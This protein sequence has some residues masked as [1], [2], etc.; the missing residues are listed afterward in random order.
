[1][2]P[3]GVQGTKTRSLRGQVADVHGVEAVHVFRG[4]DRQ[5]NLLGVDVRGQGQ[6][7]QDAVDFVA[8]VQFGDQG[9]QVFGG[10]AFRGSVLL[11]VEADF[12]GALDL[13]ANVD[14][15]CGIVPNQHHGEPGTHARQWPELL[16]GR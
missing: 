6:L 4:I 8:A 10:R 5:Q 2:T 1:M 3:A 13:A 7:H 14:L 11:A 9:E 16:P 15:G 12:L